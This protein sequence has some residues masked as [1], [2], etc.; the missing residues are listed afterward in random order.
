[1]YPFGLA[2]D[3]SFEEAMAKMG[4]KVL[5]FDPTE[6]VNP[7]IVQNPSKNIIFHKIG[8]VAKEV[9]GEE[10]YWTLD[11]IIKDNGHL[12][13]KISFLKMDVDEAGIGM[14][15]VILEQ[16]CLILAMYLATKKNC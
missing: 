12:D 2:D 7:S 3:W 10:S 15:V 11:R 8:V 4:C 1:M 5:A 16:E 13:T 9:K 6:R 14:W